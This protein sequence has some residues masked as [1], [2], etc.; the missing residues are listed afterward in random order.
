M[1]TVI[2]IYFDTNKN[3]KSLI[4]FIQTVEGLLTT[5][6]LHPLAMLNVLHDL[7]PITHIA[8]NA[9]PAPRHQVDTSNE[10]ITA[11]GIATKV[12]LN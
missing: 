5:D 9:I 10:M 8:K 6:A 2:L 11:N 1:L 12:R 3:S 4:S 7:H